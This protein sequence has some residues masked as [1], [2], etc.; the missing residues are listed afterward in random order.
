MSVCYRKVSPDIWDDEWFI[1]QDDAMR[2]LW[3]IMITGKQVL[4]IPGLQNVGPGALAEKLRRGSE[5]VSELFR[6]LIQE[7]RIEYD[8]RLQVVRVPRAPFHNLP[9]NPNQVRGW[10]NAWKRM[11][12][13]ALKYRHIASL[14]AALEQTI[15][16]IE[17]AKRGAF[18][19]AWED[20]FGTVPEPFPN[21]SETVSDRARAS[22]AGSRE[23]G[24]GN[25][26]QEKIFVE[27]GTPPVASPAKSEARP[28][29]AEKAMAPV[30]QVFE[31]WREKL[32]PKAKLDAKRTKILTAA[33]KLY[34]VEELCKVVDGTLKNKH[35]MGDNDRGKKFVGIDLLFRDAEH[36]DD[37]IAL[38]EEG[39][40]ESNGDFE[41]GN[42]PP[43]HE[44]DPP[45]TQYVG[46]TEEDKR[47]LESFLGNGAL[48]GFTPAPPAGSAA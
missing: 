26:E 10:W 35:R 23:Q 34:S 42:I 28:S 9:D 44:P 15:S 47:V 43:P 22:G 31:Y 1:D 21:G 32:S 29:L 6:K 24:A 14:K 25:G 48:D 5:T 33:L 46:P 18:L 4:P 13:S 38:A 12:N 8:E 27:L 36:I 19:K 30:E 2:D 17:E 37:A 39:P 45:G 3:W 41:W 7:G 11:P 40:A 20:T 16:E